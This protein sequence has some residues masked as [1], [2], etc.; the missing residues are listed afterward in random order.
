[1]TRKSNLTVVLIIL[2]SLLVPNIAYVQELNVLQQLK[3]NEQEIRN[4]KKK[5]TELETEIEQIRETA[6]LAQEPT[7]IEPPAGKEGL[8]TQ[9]GCVDYAWENL[10]EH[11]ILQRNGEYE[12]PAG[13]WTLAIRKLL[14]GSAR[15]RKDSVVFKSNIEELNSKRFEE[16][17]ERPIQFYSEGCAYTVTGLSV[18]PAGVRAVL[19]NIDEG[20]KRTEK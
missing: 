19:L 14:P 16:D 2:V 7:K 20:I 10:G 5:I 11:R 4:L 8:N 3:R 13:G 12:F 17:L 1:M 6:R 15:S 18:A 9:T